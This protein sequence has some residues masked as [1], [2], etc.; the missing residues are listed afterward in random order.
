MTKIALAQTNSNP[1]PD[2]ASEV[3]EVIDINLTRSKGL[4][5]QAADEGASLLAFP[6]MFMGLFGPEKKSQA[7]QSLEGEMVSI[8]REQAAKQGIMLLLGSLYEANPNDPARVFNTSVL[9]GSDGTVLGSYRKQMLFNIDL[10]KIQ[11]RESD[12]IAP[13]TLP[14]PVIST[15]IGNIG[16]T[17]CFD[18]RFSNIYADLRSQGAQIVFV[19]SNFTVPTGKAHWQTLLQARA[20]EGQF[21]IAAPAQV[22]RVSRNFNAYGHSMLVDPWGRMNALIED[23]T[24]LLYGEIDLDLLH[25]VRQELPMPQT[26]AE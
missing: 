9:I 23:D 19:P 20:I 6:E 3:G 13:G 15:P 17:I 26:K 11:F 25:K 5:R 21:Y 24:G 7:A 4:I 18:L 16:L 14:A 2:R 12:S 8:F 22:G 10:P 1:F